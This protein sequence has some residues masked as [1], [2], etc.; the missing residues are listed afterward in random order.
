MNIGDFEMY[1]R[2]LLDRTGLAISEDKDYLL[3]SR[4]TPVAKKW[5]YSTLGAMTL[6]LR[7]L[8]SPDLVH[9]VLEAMMDHETEFF[10]DIT[11]FDRFRDVVLPALAEGPGKDKSV[12]IW[13]A[14]CATGQEA[15]SLSILLQDEKSRLPAGCRVEIIGTDLSAMCIDYAERAVYSQ[16][17]SQHGMPIAVLY[18][19]FDAHEGGWKAKR[20]LRESVSFR[21][22]NLTDPL[23]RIGVFDVIF[24]RNVLNRMDKK[25]AVQILGRMTRCLMPGGFLL[26]GSD[27]TLP[28]P[29]AWLR[30]VEHNPGLY[31]LDQSYGAG[32]GDSFK[33]AGS[34]F[35]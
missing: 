26:L 10:R 23:K 33:K 34:F 31:T 12:R 17:E 29:V 4:L 22:L 2:L 32:G 21:R 11:G 15:Y 3:E 28:G 30:P 6:A 25:I 1:R 16:F 13:S 7:G 19:Y 8:A 5:K 27:E 35:S 24:C 14:G 9:D 18:K 20:L